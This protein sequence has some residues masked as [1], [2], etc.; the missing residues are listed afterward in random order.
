MMVTRSSG[1]SM[2]HASRFWNCPERICARDVTTDSK[3]KIGRFMRNILSH[4]F[5]IGGTVFMTHPYC[6][7]VIRISLTQVAQALL[8]AVSTIVSRRSPLVVSG[9]LEGACSQQDLR[10]RRDYP[11]GEADTSVHISI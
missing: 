8:P 6:Y 4:I 1:V 11:T 10:T 7:C 5:R 9:H 3:N 2:I